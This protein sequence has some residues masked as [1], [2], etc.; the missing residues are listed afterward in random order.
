MCSFLGSGI[1]EDVGLEVEEVDEYKTSQP[2]P[3]RDETLQEERRSLLSREA[4]NCAAQ[5]VK[6]KTDPSDSQT[7]T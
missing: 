7:E 6:T 1:E 2:L 3:W 5:D 4:E